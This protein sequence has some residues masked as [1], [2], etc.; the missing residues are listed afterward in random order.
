[1]HNFGE[2]VST[3]VVFDWTDKQ[4]SERQ[5]S[6]KNI[7]FM[8][9]IFSSVIQWGLQTKENFTVNRLKMLLSQWTTL[10]Q[11]K[12]KNDKQKDCTQHAVFQFNHTVCTC[13]E[14]DKSFIW[15]FMSNLFQQKTATSGSVG[16]REKL[17]W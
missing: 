15:E 1:M 14:P 9:L 13:R 5:I 8:S 2:N 3:F 16:A 11:K 12:K 10:V 6:Q 17:F 7:I 4:G